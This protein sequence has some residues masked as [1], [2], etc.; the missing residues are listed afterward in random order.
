M[1][2]QHMEAKKTLSVI[3]KVKLDCIPEI[4]KIKK[5]Q[6]TLLLQVTEKGVFMLFCDII[7]KTQN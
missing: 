1:I 7:R 4:F 2:S 5:M 3:L 6:S